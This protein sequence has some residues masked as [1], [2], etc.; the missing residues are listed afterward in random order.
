MDKDKDGQISYEEFVQVCLEV[1]KF[2]LI[3]SFRFL[4][5]IFCA[6]RMRQ[7]VNLCVYLIRDFNCDRLIFI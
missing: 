1:F 7:F 5:Y 2:L 6:Y 4:F 3:F